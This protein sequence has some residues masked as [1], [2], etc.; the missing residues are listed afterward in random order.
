MISEAFLE[1]NVDCGSQ[2]ARIVDS[3][4][5]NL[6]STTPAWLTMSCCGAIHNI[7]PNH[8]CSIQEFKQTPEHCEIFSL[9]WRKIMAIEDPSTIQSCS[10][11]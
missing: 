3:H 6:F 10:A 1:G 4:H 7:I 8:I 9:D 2:K 11:S 5:A